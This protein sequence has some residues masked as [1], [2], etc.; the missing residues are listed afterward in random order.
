MS[1]D[2]NKVKSIFLAAVAKGNSDQAAPYVDEACAGD[3]A[4]RRRVQILLE[5][6]AGEDRLL[7]F[8]AANIGG[9][10]DQPSMSESPGTVIGPYKLLEQIGEGGFGVV[11]MAE[12]QQP[13]RRK[14]ALKVLKPGMD[15]RQV[16]ARFEA[17]RQAL[18]LMDHP[19]IAQVFDGGTTGGEPGGL[20]PGRPY[21]VMEL[22]RGIPVTD[23]CDQN[24]LSIGQRLDLF[25]SV[26]QAVQHAHQKGVIHRDLKPSNVLVTLHDDKAV[27]KVI[28]F[29]V[30]K[31]TGQQLTEKTLFTNFAQMIGTPL[32]MSPE[33]A[34]M[35]GLDVDTRS[36]IYS[37]GVL[38]YEL[39]TGTTPFD[40]ERFKEVGYDEMRRIIR[41]EE[42][43]K[44]ST[45]ISTLGQAATT[46]SMH[47]KSDPK[48]L[49][50]LFRG[51]LDWIVMKCLEKDRNR[52]YETASAL[53]AD[54]ERYLRDEPVQA[55]PPS[56]GYRFRKFLR[57]HKVQ[58]V[59]VG[60]ISFFLLS[61]G[62]GAGWAV[63]DRMSRQR[64]QQEKV[65]AALAE[66]EKLSQAKKFAHALAVVAQ[67]QELFE[68]G[69]SSE[70]LRQRLHQ[71]RADL[72]LVGRL[73]EAQ[74][75]A[76][77]VNV[78]ENRFSIER[79]LPSY[80]VAF[81]RYGITPMAMAADQVAQL[82]GSQPP[83]IQMATIVALDE[84]F[85]F[86]AKDVRDPH[87]EAWLRVVLRAADADPWRTRVRAALE[88][89]EFG[90][91]VQLASDQ[92]ILK[93]ASYTLYL[94]GR[95]L[96]G[97]AAGKQAGIAVLRWAQERHP[98]SF[99]INATLGNELL[100]AK[101]PEHAEAVRFCSIAVALQPDNAGALLNLGI[102]LD[103]QGKPR[104]AIA[105]LRKAAELRP[106]YLAV[107][108]QLGD[109][110]IRHRQFDKAIEAY[111][112][113]I[114]LPDAAW[115][116]SNVVKA[117]VHNNL[118]AALE[119]RGKW[120]EAILEYRQAI[121]EKP[122]L[123]KTHH[124]LG[125]AL[126]KLGKLDQAIAAY[127]KAID[128]KAD[129]AEAHYNL[130]IALGKLGERDQAIAAYRKAID[131]NPKYP[132]AHYN[133]G[134]ALVEQGKVD[135]ASAEYQRVIQLK[136]DDPDA[137]YSLG[138][139]FQMQGRLDK[140]IIAY[141][142]A[143][144]LKP[145]YAETHVNL[146]LCLAGQ[147]KLDEAIEECSQAINLKPELANAWGARGAI[148]GNR[149]Q[150]DKAVA[151]L[152]KAIQLA[153][154]DLQVVGIYLLRA[155]ANSRLA[156][157]AEARRDCESALKRAP[158]N[159]SVLNDLAWLLATCP[160][161]KLRDPHRA[162]VLGGKAVAAAPKTGDYW[163]TLG[164]AH[165]RAGDWKAAITALDKSVK[166]RQGGDA[167]D[168]LFLAMAHWQLGNRDQARK[169][170]DHAVQW[171]EKNKQA[172]EKD[173]ARAEEF[174]RFRI[175]AEEVLELKKK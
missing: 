122:D 15:T 135:Q 123:P 65:T 138:R 172:L 31:A 145:N 144:R 157:F 5:A 141:R 28:D 12:Q 113:A 59:F 77:Q 53:A 29:G 140:A 85:S 32:Y 54:V 35:S 92:D 44:P 88:R 57:R 165:Y 7:D 149:G 155:Q 90:A 37:L 38:L 161:V 100:K 99:L 104:E 79:V 133:L 107:Y 60:L 69:G 66:V 126:T 48:R 150:Y 89:K 137:H 127:R 6:H 146:G 96:C 58:L 132:H 22:V 128:L 142:E 110:F 105:A 166:L 84:W 55:F 30:A 158:A 139:N 101:P 52:R 119:E 129:F 125:I 114:E 117:W 51:E 131:L 39:L 130:G 86:E 80:E 76:T 63:R 67:A 108:L 71:W 27:V 171:L 19:N 175:E 95:V 20:S 78:V 74:M 25:L 4:L 82:I 1:D 136:P 154:D 45:R 3:D 18:A 64:L 61:L 43:P 68:E 70:E 121:T 40:K 124:N 73:Q 9:T 41:E 47:R 26:C 36:D 97:R 81:Q 56:A 21:F 8:S 118:G 42:P 10:I 112:Q 93:Q 156:H 159:A 91:L 62:G 167:V 49:S 94:L 170:Y 147:G 83:E 162:V 102:A 109:V 16:I 151:D 111:R 152:S 173:T 23:F 143:M 106:D 134:G 116:H 50:Q 34:Q 160:G 17:E 98:D 169:A 87:R 2:V 72:E 103:H 33:Q 168:Y 148:Y 14:V 46:L 164:V 174:L 115:A 13:V 75:L 24:R 11:F 163:N 120:D 153:P